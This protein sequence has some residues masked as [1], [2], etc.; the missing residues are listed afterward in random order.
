MTTLSNII[1]NLKSSMKSSRALAFIQREV[2]PEDDVQTR[3]KALF[4]AGS[5][6]FMAVLKIV[7]VVAGG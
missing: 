2:W 7:M 3:R 1:I 4:I 6:V 5:C